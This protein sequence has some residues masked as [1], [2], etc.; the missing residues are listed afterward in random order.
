MH[1]R[2]PV[3]QGPHILKVD[4]KE[5]TFVMAIPVLWRTKKQRYSLTGV[6]CPECSQLVF[7][8]RKVCPYCLRAAEDANLKRAEQVET[9]RP[10][11][12]LFTL[13]QGSDARLAG[14]D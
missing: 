2:L 6:V 4:T 14:D 10:Y 8:P 13:G 7:P 11:R 12:F 9:E 3:W 5:S 1:S